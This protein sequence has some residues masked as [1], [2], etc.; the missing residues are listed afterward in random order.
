MKIPK[1]SQIVI[2]TD[3]TVKALYGDDLKNKLNANLIAIPDGEGS[4]SRTMKAKIEDEMLDM[5]CDRDTLI[6]ALGGGVVGDLAGFVAST[7]MRGI[8]FI[9]I[10]T[11]LLAMVDSSIG[12]KT[13]INVKH[14]KNLIGTFWKAK[15]IYLD[16]HY[17]RSLPKEH[18][19]NGLVEAVKMFLTHDRESFSYVEEKL[20][21]ILAKDE[22]AL[23]Y[24]IEKARS[25]KFKVVKQDE[26]EENQ[27]ILLNFGHTVGHGLEKLSN[28]KI[29]H[30]KAVGFGILFESKISQI[31]GSLQEDAF[32]RVY[33][34][35]MRLGININEIDYNEEEIWKAMLND[36]KNRCGELMYV[37]LDSIGKASYVNAL[38]RDI[39]KTAYKELL[40][41]EIHLDNY[42]K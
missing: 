29:M 32:Q 31:E 35:M 26:R 17:L 6:I 8:P 7:Y 15:D 33:R 10:P 42:L 18:I 3:E 9:Q 22:D 28:Y 34:F 11:T 16:V 38:N 40:C 23:T 4:K 20:D 14:G 2:I 30:G 24:L 1:A 21:A 25:I 5:A 36:K 37:V 27:R 19:V 41:P 13:A 39:F 12:G